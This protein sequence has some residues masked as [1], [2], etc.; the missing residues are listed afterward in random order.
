MVTR[1]PGKHNGPDVGGGACGVGP[2][3]SSGSPFRE[4]EIYPVSSNVIQSPIT[5]AALSQIERVGDIM[6]AK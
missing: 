5:L 4:A 6:A 3:W 1:Q 2:W